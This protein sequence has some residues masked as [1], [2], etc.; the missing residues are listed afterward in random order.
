MKSYEIVF[1]SINK[2]SEYVKVRPHYSDKISFYDPTM[3]WVLRNERYTSDDD[4]F[5]DSGID[6]TRSAG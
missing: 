3:G 6:R 2:L 4:S 5:Q 1:D